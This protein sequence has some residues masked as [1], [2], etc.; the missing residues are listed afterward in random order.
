MQYIRM[1]FQDKFLS[2]FM[3]RLLKI[4]LFLPFFHQVVFAQNNNIVSYAGGSGTERFNSILRLSNGTYLI[5]GQADELDWLPPGVTVNTLTGVNRYGSNSTLA[6][7]FIIQVSADMQT[8]LGAVKFPDNTVRDVFKIKTNSLASQATGDIYISGNRDTTAGADGY[9][10]ARLNNNFIGGL[11]T[12]VVYYRSID[13]RTRNGG[14]ANIQN[15]PSGNESAVKQMQPWDVNDKGQI[16]YATGHDFSFDRAGINFMNKMGVDTLMDYFSIH[17]PNF[18]GVPASSFVNTTGNPGFD[19]RSSFLWFKFT[20]TG[21]PGALRSYNSDLYNQINEDENGNPGRKGAFP[22]DAFFASPQLLGGAPIST[23]TPGYTGYSY[24]SGGGRWTARIGSITFDKRNGEFYIG[25]SMSVNSTSNLPNLDD[26]EPAIAAFGPTGQL[27]WWARLHKEDGQRSP[28]QQHIE[29]LEIDYANNQLV[30]L[31]RSKGNGPNNFWKGNELKLKPGGKGYQNQITN[32]NL[33][34]EYPNFGWLGK[35]RLNDGK[36]LHS[37][38]IGELTASQAFLSASGNP[39]YEGYPD[40]NSYN[41]SLGNTYVNGLAVDEEGKVIVSG[42]AERTMATANAYQKMYAPK[43]IATGGG[44]A[45]VNSFIRIY[46]PSLDSVSY[47]S[48]LTGLY[49]PVN[50]NAD[51]T[52]IR[53]L[54]PTPTGVLFTGFDNGTGSNVATVNIPA[55]GT[56]GKNGTSGLFGRLNILTQNAPPS[57]PDTI[58]RPASFCTGNTFTFSVSPVSGADSYIWIVEGNGWAGNSTTNSI[59]LTQASNASA[60]SLRVYALNGTGVSLGRVTSLP[61]VANT[62]APGGFLF[63]PIHCANQTRN[64]LVNPVAGAISYSWSIS[65]AGCDA[66]WTLGAASTTGNTVSISSGATVITPCSLTVVANGCNGSSNPVS[67]PLPGPGAGPNTPVF[68]SAA[69]APCVGIPKTYA[70]NSDILAQSYIW[71]VSG[72]G[73]SG[74]STGSSIEITAAAGATNGV[75]TV[76][77]VNECGQSSPAILNI[78]DVNPEGAPA[79]PSAILGPVS[80]FCSVAD[81]LTYSVTQVPGLNY[82]WTTNGNQWQ[83]FPGTSPNTQ[84]LYIPQTGSTNN[85]FLFVQASNACGT[86]LPT[87]LQIRRGIPSSGGNPILPS[88]NNGVCEGSNIT[89][90]INPILGANTYAWTFPGGWV[91]SGPSDQTSVTVSPGPGAISGTIK[92]KISNSCGSDSIQR[93]SPEKKSSNV[94]FSIQPA[95]AGAVNIC[96]GSSR[97]LYV[98]GITDTTSIVS[99]SWGQLPPGVFVTRADIQGPQQDTVRL[100]VN[101]QASSGEVRVFLQSN[102]NKC[103]SATI[104]LI[105]TPNPAPSGIAG[106]VQLCQNPTDQTYRARSVPGALSYEFEVAPPS[107]GSITVSDTTATINWADAFVGQAIVRARSISNC[108]PS[109][110]SSPLFVNLGLPNAISGGNVNIC[111]AGSVSLEALGGG[112]GL[113]YNWYDAAT[114]GSL[115]QNTPN[116]TLLFNVSGTDTIYV[117][118]TNGT[119]ESNQRTPIIINQIGNPAPP[120]VTNNGNCGPGLVALS[121]STPLP[122]ATLVWFDSLSGGNQVFTG[123]NY[124]PN[125]SQT[126]TFYVEVQLGSCI[127][128]RA[129][130]I[131]TINPLPVAPTS[132]DVSRCGSGTVDLTASGIVGA[133]YTW[134]NVAT[135]GTALGTGAS[136]TTP[137]ISATTTFYISATV[138]GCEGTRTAVNAVVNP[139]PAAPTSSDVPRCGPGTLDLTAS[140]I[141]G[142]TYTWYNVATGGTALGT[143]ASFT[144]PNISATTTYYVSATVAGCEGT[145]TAVNAVVN[146][147]PAAPTSSDVSRCGPGT[148]DLTASGIAGATYTWYNVA[149]GGIALGTGASFTTPN[150]S[151]TSTFYVSATVAGCESPRTTVNATII[152]IPNAPVGTNGERCGEGTVN[153]SANGAPGATLIWHDAATGGN[154]LATGNNYTTLSISTT[155]SYFVSANINGCSSSRTEVIATINPLPN[156]PTGTDAN[157]CGPGTVVLNVQAPAGTFQWYTTATGG[158]SIS[159]ANSFTTPGLTSTTSFFASVKVG[160]CESPRVEIKAIIDE[161]P[162]KPTSQGVGICNP[163][164]ITLNANGG[165]NQVNWYTSRTATNSI[166]TGPSYTFNLSVNTFIYFSASTPGGCESERDSVLA[167]LLPKPVVPQAENISRCGPGSVT[168]T[169]SATGIQNFSWF[170]EAS[171]GIS[172]SNTNP[173]SINVNSSDS[174][175]VVSIGTNGCESERKEVKVEIKPFPVVEVSANPQV[176]EIG[177]STNLLVTGNGGIVWTPN[178][179]LSNNSIATPLASPIT[180]TIYKA[181]VNLN[182]CIRTDSIEIQVVEPE[183]TEIPNVFTPNGDGIKDKWEIPSALTKPKNSLKVFNRWGNLVKEFAPYRN[184]WDGDKLPDGTYYYTYSDGEETKTGTVTI[185]H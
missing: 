114:G 155:T 106:P 16:L 22:N 75:L 95:V 142:A 43:S 6:K 55:W 70:V 88:L 20:G 42:T 60:G 111:G 135:G 170:E 129:L 100:A 162:S 145:R 122:G 113:T 83:L 78:G 41:Y 47:S 82:I 85:S 164:P 86:S 102:N 125:L 143:G 133:T 161:P 19:L 97:I 103:G 130:V 104:N 124:S 110:F 93:S 137:N 29:G 3:V 165:G 120:T 136:F 57:Q 10:I 87:S 33:N 44:A 45:P 37:T 139:A 24:N 126:D 73:Y 30:V 96:S 131:G 18:T 76:V 119:C 151:A 48:V 105:V 183:I 66:G 184:D 9:Y 11:P 115:L 91:V 34:S 26:A 177:Q 156:A 175:F 28:A 118:L 7:G 157:R 159:N 172:I 160:N 74:S 112:N 141:A 173:F 68:S 89:F 54:L 167:G 117:T 179:N 51:N 171:G 38:Y 182:G 81:T 58:V 149:T 67:F 178:I 53:S 174:Y 166:S 121:A 134:Y 132:S 147:A 62:V 8:I 123:P 46:N 98:D 158:S 116:G 27:K 181:T 90:S 56:S 49:N 5:G 59:T 25:F 109:P 154:N 146:P 15:P 128:T 61:A 1:L 127:S 35:Y 23:S 163:G 180:T 17:V 31:G 92:V 64:Y 84:R 50:G 150:I 152:D 21:T 4:L 71:T 69:S 107:A 63:P 36:I 169:A 101:T 14:S 148:L 13:A 32:Y 2:S 108:G 185:I 153:L 138:A 140:G 12:G 99:F 52:F 144:T 94:N 65:G 176:I 79:T 168:L 77:A 80:G 72:T 40:L 39:N